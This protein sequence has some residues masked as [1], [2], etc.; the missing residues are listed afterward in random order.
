MF[1]L[2]SPVRCG[3]CITES[4][5]TTRFS[6][7]SCAGLP[8][9]QQLSYSCV[10]FNKQKKKKHITEKQAGPYNWST[11]IEETSISK[12]TKN[13]YSYL[14]PHGILSALEYKGNRSLQTQLKNGKKSLYY[15][16]HQSWRALWVA[17][18]TGHVI[19]LQFLSSIQYY[20]MR[21]GQKSNYQSG[22]L[23]SSSR[24]GFQTWLSSLVSY[25]HFLLTAV[26]VTLDHLYF[27]KGF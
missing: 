23:R 24:Q 20:G 4:C 5:V 22:L 27:L 3:E 10:P 26:E 12:H 17:K 13:T 7:Y 8:E 1:K 2:L 15:W 11:S 6:L 18:T 14:S 16:K 25:H 19:I 21:L 9:S